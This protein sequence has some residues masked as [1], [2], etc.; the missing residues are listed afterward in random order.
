MKID[1]LRKIS[2]DQI[3][4]THKNY[5]QLKR[6]VFS[7]ESTASSVSLRHHHS[8]IARQSTW[9][10]TGVVSVKGHGVKI[11]SFRTLKIFRKETGGMKIIQDNAITVGHVRVQI[12]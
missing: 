9:W 3:I 11:K 4:G 8:F 6:S 7:P 2:L 10:M 1:V 5:L 12:T